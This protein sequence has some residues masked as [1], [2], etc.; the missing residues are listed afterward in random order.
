MGRNRRSMN[1]LIDLKIHKF[2]T[3]SAILKA[4]EETH[5]LLIELE[6]LLL[7]WDK[8]GSNAP[9]KIAHCVANTAEEYAD[10]SISVFDTFRRIWKDDFPQIVEK[11]RSLV[12]TERLPML[13]EGACNEEP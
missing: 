12:Y 11:K 6:T 7:L 13:L 8:Y 3:R 9:R 5:E 2:G 1:D 10:V 4:I